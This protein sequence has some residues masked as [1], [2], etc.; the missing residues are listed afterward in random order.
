MPTILQSDFIITWTCVPQGLF[1]TMLCFALVLLCFI[2]V[3]AAHIHRSTGPVVEND[4]IVYVCVSLSPVKNLMNVCSV[5]KTGVDLSAHIGNISNSIL[6]F[7]GDNTFS[8]KYTYNT[9]ESAA[10]IHPCH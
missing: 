7:D 6:S 10:H 3:L 5:L 2:D 8:V 1:P 9:S 4:Y